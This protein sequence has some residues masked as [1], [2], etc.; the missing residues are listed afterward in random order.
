M[1]YIQ[2]YNNVVPTKIFKEDKDWIY[3]ISCW[4]TRKG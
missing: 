3:S 1:N 4:N 2:F